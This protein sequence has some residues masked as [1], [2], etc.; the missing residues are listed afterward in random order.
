[1]SEQQ[2]QVVAVAAEPGIPEVTDLP[3]GHVAGRLVALTVPD[4]EVRFDAALDEQLD[5]LRLWWPDGEGQFCWQLSENPDGTP[6]STRTD[7]ESFLDRSTLRETG[8]ELPLVL[9]VS[10]HGLFSASARHYLKLPTTSDRRLLATAVPTAH[11]AYAALDSLAQHVL[12]VLNMCES[13]AV[14]SELISL[15]G[16]LDEGRKDSAVLNVLGTAVQGRPVLG[17]ELAKLLR[18]AH[19]LVTTSEQ[20]ARPHLK[21]SEFTLLLHN[22]AESLEAERPRRRQP[23]KVSEQISVPEMLLTRWQHKVSPALPNPGYRPEPAVAEPGLQDV[24]ASYRQLEYWMEKASGRLDQADGGWY[25]SGREQLN[26]Q[27][28]SFLHE[29]AGVRIVAGSAGTGKSALL[30]RLVTMSDRVFRDSDRYASA[31]RCRPDSI[32]AVGAVT[33]AL[34]ARHRSAA[35]ALR[36]L[37]AELGCPAPPA[38]AGISAWQQVLEDFLLSPG[39]PVTVVIDS[40]DEAYEPGQFI[41]AVLAPFVSATRRHD[42]AAVVS[43]PADAAFVPG[44][45]PETG[46]TQA[47]TVRLLLGVRSTRR[48][49]ASSDAGGTAPVGDLLAEIT[50]RFP[51][52]EVLHSDE[53]PDSDI[54]AYVKALLQGQPHWSDAARAEAALTIS[55]HAH[56]SF[57]NAR[58]AVD[59]LRAHKDLGPRLLRSRTWLDGLSIGIAGLLRSDLHRLEREDGLPAAEALALLRAAAFAQGRG[60]A[61]GTVW[62]ALAGAVLQMPLRHPDEKISRLLKSPLAG[63]LTSDHEDDRVVYRPAHEQLAQILRRWPA[64]LKGTT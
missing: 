16:E 62:P 59:Q 5:A 45:R 29:P 9:F 28:V 1:M 31:L 11:I 24:A 22:A 58:L 14:G 53:N 32:P 56:G 47:R 57:L 39:D 43:S 2:G 52:A 20:I 23:R 10:A 38:G 46:L 15:Q 51:D 41:A 35:D 17:A 63:Y 44:P 27:L 12:V 48:T 25:F 3:A 61:W 50:D 21:M 18:R 54:R 64:D 6:L 26:L 4:G 8:P 37:T 42:P 13:S 7:V 40:L 55:E 49:R 36:Q 34:S 33:A 60:L 19:Q 30:G